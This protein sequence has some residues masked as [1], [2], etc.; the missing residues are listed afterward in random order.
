MNFLT[1][2]SETFYKDYIDLNGQMVAREGEPDPAPDSD[3]NDLSYAENLVME[4][5]PTRLT[6]QTMIV[7]CILGIP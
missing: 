1:F 6:I 3:G 4:E 5:P 7:H 2:F